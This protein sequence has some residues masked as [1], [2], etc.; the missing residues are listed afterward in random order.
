M[1]DSEAPGALLLCLDM[2]APF[3]DAVVDG[4]KLTQRC[5]LALQ[6]ARGLGID[7]AL[8]EQVPAKLGPTLPEIKAA[9]GDAPILGKTTFSALAEPAVAGLIAERE[10]AHLILC[11]LETPICVYQT[12]LDAL[13]QDLVVTVL[14]DAVGAR[15]LDDATRV[16]EALSRHGA[17]V[18]PLESVF[19]ALLHDASHPY[20]RTF[21]QLVKSHG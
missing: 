8:T 20:F 10:V 16:I 5:A 17:H 19:Y 18:L 7:V 14:S 11:G 9:A 4:A 13:N 6:A 3:I 12:A 21:T 2:Q 15:R 1:P